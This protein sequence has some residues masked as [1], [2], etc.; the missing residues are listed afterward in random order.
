MRIENH[1]RLHE[2]ILSKIDE[3]KKSCCYDDFYD[4][5]WEMW[6][7]EIIKKV[8]PKVVVDDN[9]NIIGWFSAEDYMGTQL[10][11]IHYAVDDAQEY[12]VGLY[13]DS[14]FICEK[15]SK[16]LVPCDVG[17]YCIR[18]RVF[19]NGDPDKL[20]NMFEQKYV[21]GSDDTVD[22]LEF[23]DMN[24]SEFSVFFRTYNDP[25]FGIPAERK[26]S[27]FY[28]FPKFRYFHCEDYCDNNIRYLIARDASTKKIAGV[29]HYGKWPYSG[30]ILCISY[31]DVARGAQR[32][33]IATLL[34]TQLNRVLKDYPFRQFRIGR[35]SHN[36][37]EANIDK[38]FKREIKGFEF[39]D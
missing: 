37:K 32:H 33:G 14:F 25:L 3:N 18:R 10:V 17:Q 27:N 16:S 29:I 9:G 2:F 12:I 22:N 5:F 31:I 1:K 23:L 39:V 26:D 36:G 24:M 13:P 38:I 15:E 34:I 28:S 8:N 20:K 6:N 21:F 11:T 30:D 4:F 19:T 35:L 7:E